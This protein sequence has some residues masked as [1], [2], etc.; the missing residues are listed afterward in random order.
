M[1]MA[2]PEEEALEEARKRRDAG[3]NTIW[4]HGR[5]SRGRQGGPGAGVRGCF[6]ARVAVGRREN[7]GE[8]WSVVLAMNGPRLPVS[9]GRRDNS[10]TRGSAFR[11]AGC[12]SVFDPCV[13]GW[14]STVCGCEILEKFPR[15][16]APPNMVTETAA[17]VLLE[18]PLQ[19]P[20]PV[21]PPSPPILTPT[22]R[23]RISPIEFRKLW[24][25]SR[26]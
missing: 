4:R 20:N 22:L 8:Y 24:K 10:P 17:Q 5:P 18:S 19:P 7:A 2:Y 14:G 11:T 13:H 12:V 26:A 1:G 16:A 15:R 23:S 3:E 25:F 21:P 9:Q 6:P